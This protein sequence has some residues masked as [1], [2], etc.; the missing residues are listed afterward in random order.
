MPLWLSI[1][2]MVIVVIFYGL[3]VLVM[4]Q[5]SYAARTVEIQSEQK[6]IDTGMYSIVR[7]PMYMVMIPIYLF[8]PLALGSYIAVIAGLLFPFTLILRIYNE[9][10]I[11]ENG[12]NG[13]KEYMNRVKYRLIPYIW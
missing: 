7:H 4:I 11:L 8:S 6:L 13:Y 2:S 5:N 9:E 12:L 3:N 10:K 1:V